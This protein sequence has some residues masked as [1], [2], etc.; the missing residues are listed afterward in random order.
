MESHRIVK[1][2]T[3]REMLQATTAL[4]G[5]ALVAGLLPGNLACAASGN[6]QQAGKAPADPVA[7]FRA[8]MASAPI[9]TKISPIISPCFP[10]PAEMLWC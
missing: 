2:T 9:Q 1:L 8:Q 7:A 4:A 10:V 6:A 5:G 3:R